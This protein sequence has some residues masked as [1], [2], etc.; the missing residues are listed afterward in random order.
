MNSNG[1]ANDATKDQSARG[2]RICN[3]LRLHGIDAD[4]QLDNTNE[5]FLI[6]DNVN[7]YK[8]V[9]VRE[10]NGQKLPYWVHVTPIVNSIMNRNIGINKIRFAQV[11]NSVYFHLPMEL[12]VS[13]LPQ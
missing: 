6:L 1:P 8:C 10:F 11:K 2:E 12:S 3:D 7:V 13:N 5:L 4:Y 9:G